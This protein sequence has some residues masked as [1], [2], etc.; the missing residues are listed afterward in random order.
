MTTELHCSGKRVPGYQALRS[1]P[2]YQGKP[3]SV[4]SPQW[5]QIESC[6]MLTPGFAEDRILSMT[7]MTCSWPDHSLRIF[8]ITGKVKTSAEE[9]QLAIKGSWVFLVVWGDELSQGL[10]SWRRA[11]PLV[12]GAFFIGLKSYPAYRECCHSTTNFLEALA[13]K[14]RLIVCDR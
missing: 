9:S 12:V 6:V 5:I 10:D 13:Q 2:F 8:H 1:I 3:S 14:F 11:Q 7:L 4:H